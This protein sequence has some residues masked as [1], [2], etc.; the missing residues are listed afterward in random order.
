MSY[1]SNDEV[2]G[3]L[4]QAG[5]ERVLLPNATVAEVMSRVAVEP[6]PGAPAW[7]AGQIAW[8]G[9]NVPLLAFARF[10]GL[11]EETLTAN[12][13]VVV[14]KALGGNPDLPYFALLTASFPQLIAVPRDGLLADASEESLPQG[15]HMRVLLGEQSALLPDLD[16]VEAAITQSLAA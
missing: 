11:G 4:I 10:S 3:V 15:V 5:S 14:L 8:H 16:A 7:M 13:K 6:I 2:R 1:A 9:W 12:N